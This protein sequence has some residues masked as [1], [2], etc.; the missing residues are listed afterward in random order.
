MPGGETTRQFVC[1]MKST[2]NVFGFNQSAHQ[3]GRESA[4]LFW[5]L[6]VWGGGGGGGDETYIG[7]SCPNVAAAGSTQYNIVSLPHGQSRAKCR[8]FLSAGHVPTQGWTPIIHAIVR[9]PLNWLLGP[10]SGEPI[11]VCRSMNPVKKLV[12][13]T[14]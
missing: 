2:L 4:V 3:A 7:K 1:V 5:G 14:G 9:S 10:C 13:S 8:L 12:V 6:G 11:N